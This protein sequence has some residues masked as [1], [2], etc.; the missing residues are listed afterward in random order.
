MSLL[1]KQS[2]T[3]KIE[4]DLGKIKEIETRLSRLKDF[5]PLE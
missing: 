3:A 4:E 1:L 2:T 5:P